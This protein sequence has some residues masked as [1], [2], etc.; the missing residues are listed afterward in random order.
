MTHDLPYLK[1]ISKSLQADWFNTIWGN[2][3]S[4]LSHELKYVA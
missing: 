2:V 4:N 3:S 1:W